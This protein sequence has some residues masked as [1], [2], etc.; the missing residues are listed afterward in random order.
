LRTMLSK[1]TH[2]VGIPVRDLKD[3]W[4]NAIDAI[5]KLE[6][7]GHIMVV[8]HKKDQTP[9]AVW[10]NQVGL[11][12]T[13]IDDNY[14]TMFN[15]VQIPS[16]PDELRTKLDSAGLKPTSKPKAIVKAPEEKKKKKAA[17]K[18]G[19]QTNLHMQGILKDYSH[20]RK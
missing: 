9:K 16:N 11:A 5:N 12:T 7:E 13:K 3:G 10:H 8:R 2:A 6:K 15:R 20:K 1:Q 4:P 17:R 18:S 19:K 14:K